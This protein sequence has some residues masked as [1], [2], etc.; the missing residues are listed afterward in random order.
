[1][2]VEVVLGAD[3]EH[4]AVDL[5]R[6]DRG[7]ARVE[8]DDVRPARGGE[9]RALEHVRDEHLAGEPAARAAAADRRHAVDRGGLEVVGGRVPA[10]RARARRGRRPTAADSTTSGSGGPP[11]PIAT[12]T[13]SWSR[14]SSRA[15]CAG[16]RRLPDALAAS[17]SPRSSGGRSNAAY[18]GG[19]KRKSAPT[20]GEPGRERARRPAQPLGRAEHRL[21]GEVDHDLGVAEVRRAAARRSRAR[22]AASRCRRRGSRRPTRTAARRAPR[23]RPR[24]VLAVDERDR[25][26]RCAVTSRSIRP[27]YFSY[28]SVARSNW[29]IRSWPWNG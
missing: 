23:G 4:A 9:P 25:L 15:R 14:A 13:T 27:V 11:R 2:R 10:R 5:D 3:D 12:T 18:R 1:M 22:R 7:A 6:R 19:S 24:A 20:Y 21:V 17:R 29:M 8:D 28:S 16:D 26:H